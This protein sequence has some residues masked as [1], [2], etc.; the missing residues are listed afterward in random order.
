[1]RDTDEI[2]I[3]LRLATISGGSVTGEGELHVEGTAETSD[4][5]SHRFSGWLDLLDTLET[6]V[7]TGAEKG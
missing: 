4:G 3:T 1:M 2:V 6:A 5:G 7:R